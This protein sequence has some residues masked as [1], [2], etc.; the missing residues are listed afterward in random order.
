MHPAALPSR[1]HR[2][3][4]SLRSNTRHQRL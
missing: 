4:R 3:D 2:G 1:G